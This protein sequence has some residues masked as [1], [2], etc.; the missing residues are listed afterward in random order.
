LRNRVITGF[1]VLSASGVGREPFWSDVRRDARR[2]SSRAGDDA[3][4]TVEVPGFDPAAILGDKGLRALD[5]LTK[6]LL[7]ATRLTLRDAGLKTDSAWADSPSGRRGWPERVG[8]VVSNA[9]GSLEA[10]NELDRVALLEDPRYINPSRFPLTVSNSAA[11]YASIWEDLRALN[12]TVSNGQCGALDAVSCADL[13]L[14]GERADVLLVGGV[15]ALSEPLTVGCSRLGV[16]FGG[17]DAEPGAV[18]PGLG[19]GAALFAIETPAG[20]RERGATALAEL[21]GYGTS[22]EPPRAEGSLIAATP[23]ALER[24]IAEALDDADVAPNE[25]DVVMSGL[26]GNPPFDRAER[27]AIVAALGEQAYIAAPKL[28]F[29][30]TFGAAGALGMAATL[31]CL[32]EP[33]AAFAVR[34]TPRGR[35]RTVLLTALGYYGNASALVMRASSS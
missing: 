34:G 33:N 25:V 19:E 6:L 16:S 9:Y 20:A 13:L 7:V 26:S 11:G 3:L 4:P 15:E 31:A 30:E 28:A 27:D 14:D 35:I 29:G 5:R 23:I 22:L 18:Y 21:L 32:G 17:P 8:L 24:S 10:I 1:G 12:V 2:S